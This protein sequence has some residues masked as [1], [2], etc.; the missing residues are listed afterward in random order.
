MPIPI[1][2]HQ[3]PLLP[4]IRRWPERF[5][6]V[7][8]VVGSVMPDVWY[9]TIP[10]PRS[11]WPVTY[12]DGHTWLGFGFRILGAGIVL[13]MLV[14][15]LWLKRWWAPAVAFEWYRL[16]WSVALG[17]ATHLVLDR[18]TDYGPPRL[19]QYVL[20]LVLG[21]AAIVMIRSWWSKEVWRWWREVAGRYQP[22]STHSSK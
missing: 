11:T 15:S 21:T 14:R 12:Y 13:T 10:L 5:D 18:I 19:V 7:G 6:A 1:L 20:S 16:A 22:R 8:L 3:A 9:L 2:A 17:G 4:L